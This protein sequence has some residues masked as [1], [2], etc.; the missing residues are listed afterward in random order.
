MTTETGA[1]TT[2]EH[3][4]GDLA[5]RAFEALREGRVRLCQSRDGAWFA[6]TT[7]PRPDAFYASDPLDA[8]TQALDAHAAVSA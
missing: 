4:R 7:H 8:V 2:L 6:S 5:I 3:S 1:M